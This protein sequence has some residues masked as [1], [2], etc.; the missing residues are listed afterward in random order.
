MEGH[1]KKIVAIMLI[2]VMALAFYACGSKEDKNTP[3][4]ENQAYLDSLNI[5][6]VD[7]YLFKCDYTEYDYDTVSSEFETLYKGGGCSAVRNG[8]LVG[9]NFDWKK[10]KEQIKNNIK[11]LIIK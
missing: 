3:T 5:E 1:M 7:N 10:D 6:K 8:D 2:G 4:G 9:R 11:N